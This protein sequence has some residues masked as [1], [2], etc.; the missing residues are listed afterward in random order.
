MRRY[1]RT[2]ARS[3]A[4]LVAA[5][6]MLGAPTTGVLAE[7]RIQPGDKLQLTV[8]NHPDLS[9]DLVVS[10]AGDVRVPVAGDVSVE[11]LSQTAATDR[12]QKAL[13]PFLF[14]PSIDMRVLSQG[15]S[16]FF[17]GSLVG[18][19]PYQPGETLG[20][21]IGAFRQAASTSGT[22]TNPAPANFN[23]IDLR[24]VRIQ[25][26]KQTFAPVDLE[27]LARSG[28]SGPRLEAGDAVLLNAKPVRVDVRGNLAGPA[29]VYLYPGDTL[30]QAVAQTGSISS[31]TSLTSIALHR[32]GKDSIVSS[33]DGTFTSA[34]HDGDIVTLEPAPRVSVLGMVEKAGDETLQTR[35]T[36][37]NA[38][39]EAG[40]PNRYAD[41]AS[42]Q[43]THEGVTRVYNVAKLTHGDLSQNA[44]I[45]DGDVVFVPEG[46]KVD[47]S[48]FTNA[49]GA[50]ASLRI[51]G[52]I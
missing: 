30:S 6:V 45:Y 27:A 43:V 21:A 25:R 1:L 51:L 4:A 7:T 2:G 31:S 41:L 32:D 23:N 52:G 47:F 10:S 36:L 46:H 35:P 12:V 11:G 39:Y 49:L 18:V 48:V 29:I 3:L 13:S 17:T 8:F 33:A 24:T 28:D 22:G 19:A 5:A 50:L 42:I 44:Q 40:G 37:L 14:H 34:A 26:D 15:Q 20:A 38:L 9:T 16:I